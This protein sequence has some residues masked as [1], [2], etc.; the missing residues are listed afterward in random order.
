MRIDLHIH[1]TASDGL[2]SPAEIVTMAKTSG[3]DILGI[4]D[5]DTVG[6]LA[7]CTEAA[8][9]HGLR[10]VPALEINSYNGSAEY[11]ILG[12]FI[13]VKNSRL[14]S[15][16]AE[17]QKSRVRRMYV[18]IS[19]LK[20]LGIPLD[21]E[22]ILEIAGDGV[23]GRPHIARAMIR[24][25][26][27]KSFREAFDKYI[28]EG[29]SAYVPRSKLTPKGAI[30]IIKEAEGLA[31]LAHPGTW[32]CDQVIPHLVSWGIVGIEVYYPEHTPGQVKK[33]RDLAR[34]FGL[35]TTGGSDFHG[36]DNSNGITIGTS[37]MPMEEFERLER[38]AGK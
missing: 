14:L 38:L 12:Y 35:V 34:A 17:L 10:I 26:H 25:G 8:H 21:A 4:A 7:E 23:V 18:M 22:E 37:C 1:T 20:S 24:N 5:H 30:R 31:V 32:G 15:T 27:V 6:G 28:G 19:R 33:Y 16:L 9:S 29:R 11:H 3:M 36:S 2:Y 13:D